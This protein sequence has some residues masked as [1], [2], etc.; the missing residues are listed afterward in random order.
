VHHQY[1][2]HLGFAGIGGGH[3]GHPAADFAVHFLLVNGKARLGKVLGL[4]HT[5]G[6][7]H[8]HKALIGP[9]ELIPDGLGGLSLGADPNL[10]IGALPARN[11]DLTGIRVSRAGRSLGGGHIVV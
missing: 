7:L 4:G 1:Q 2:G 5:A 6:K 11:I 8:G 9:Q 10:R 3:I